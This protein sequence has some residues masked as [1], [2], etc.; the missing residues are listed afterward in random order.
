MCRVSHWEWT[1]TM[2]RCRSVPHLSNRVR[3]SVCLLLLWHRSKCGHM[4]TSLFYKAVGKEMGEDKMRGVEGSVF[5]WSPV[6]RSKD[7]GQTEDNLVAVPPFLTKL[8]KLKGCNH[9][10]KNGDKDQLRMFRLSVWYL[11][12]YPQSR[13]TKA[14]YGDVCLFWSWRQED[15][16]FRVILN[17]IGSFRIAW[18]T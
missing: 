3:K 7:K 14:R 10:G 5:L 12:Y 17:S 1:C 8:L 2:V 6:R 15:S 11:T 18:H 16:E 13:F 4:H 9:L